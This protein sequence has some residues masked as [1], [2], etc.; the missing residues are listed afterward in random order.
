MTHE[1]I[2]AH[3]IECNKDEIYKE[4][5]GAVNYAFRQEGYGRL[6][7]YFEPSDGRL[8]WR[9]NFA[10]KKK[11]YKDMKTKYRVH[12]G[13]LKCWKTIE[14]RII[15]KVVEKTPNGAYKWQWIT[16]VGYSHGGALAAFCH[17]AVWFHRPDLREKGLVGIGFEPPRIYGA[18]RVKEEL[19]ERWAH[20]YVLR[21]GRDIVTHAPPRIFGFTHV[22]NIVKMKTKAGF[23]MAHTPW[24]VEKSIL[25]NADVLD[26]VFEG[27]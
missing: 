18:W 12:R 17:E 1:K 7:I 20:F 13:F 6:V 14:D 16:V 9:N 21:N 25:V 19:K 10:F 24:E 8:D 27:K 2:F 15:D 22:G 26:R 11:P 5:R 4:A 3:F 23:V